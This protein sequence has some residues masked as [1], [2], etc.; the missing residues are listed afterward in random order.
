MIFRQYLHDPFFQASYLLGCRRTSEAFI[1]DP[2]HDLGS[3]FYRGEADAMGLSVR[4][5]LET[6]VHADYISCARALAQTT[7]SPL[8]LSRFTPAQYEYA[9]LDDGDVLELGQMRIE[10]IHTPGHTPEHV[11]FLVTDV[12]RGDEPWAVLT[13][14]SLL[15]GDVGRPDLLVGDQAE[16]SSD[17][18]E[19]ARVQFENIRGRLFTLPDHVEVYPGHFGDSACG[20][21]NMSCKASSTIYFEKRHN[22]PMQRPNA[23]VFAEFVRDTAKPLPEDFERIKATNLGM[24]G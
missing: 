12:T 18:G 21:I 9:P 11:A 20:G 16:S 17:V 10:V 15:V 2:I 3:G 4:G 24:G 19:R 22:L 6:H 1:L 7:G 13:G 14:D 5:V 8:Y 23:E